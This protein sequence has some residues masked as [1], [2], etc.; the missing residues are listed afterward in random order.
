MTS[1]TTNSP[2][3]QNSLLC[4]VE[5]GVLLLPDVAVAEIIDYQ[6]VESDDDMPTWFLGLLSWRQLDIPLVSFEALKDNTF[7]SQSGQ[8]K[9]IILNSISQR[10][11]FAYWGFISAEAP[12]MRRL[13][14]DQ[15]IST[16]DNTR[17]EF[18]LA[19]ASVGGDDVLL[20]DL[21]AVEKNIADL[22]Y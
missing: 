10:D 15:V 7:F 18:I 12:K 4:Q 22:L 17:E 16:G 3:S 11:D 8:L 5:S 13:T 6:P 9:I 1:A 21:Q 2:E 14:K 20:P 19:K